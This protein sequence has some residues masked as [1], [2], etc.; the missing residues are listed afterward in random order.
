MTIQHSK[1]IT[2]LCRVT[3]MA[4]SALI[5]LFYTTPSNAAQPDAGSL[6]Q[7]QR[8][9]KPALPQRLPS[10]EVS[11]VVQEADAAST[12]TFFVREFRFTG[13]YDNLVTS[14][15]LTTLVKEHIGKECTLGELQKLMKTITNYLRNKKQYLLARAYLPPQDVTQGVIEI[16]I[17]PGHVEGRTTIEL[18]KP[19][20]ISAHLL[21]N[22]ADSAIPE[23]RPAT[24][25][26]LERA[27]LLSNDLPGVTAR[28][29]L[30]P[31]S[32]PGSTRL[33][34][35]ASEKAL[36]QGYFSGDNHGSLYTGQLRG[37]AAI[38]AYH[39]FGGGDQ[40]TLFLMSAEQMQ[41]WQASYSTL[42]FPNGLT[43]TLSFSSL[44]YN[45]ARELSNLN[46]SGSAKTYSAAL[47]YPLLRTRNA[48]IWSGLGGEALALRDK[49]N[50]VSI[51][52]RN[53][54]TGKISLTGSFFD[55][56]GG[57]GLSNASLGVTTGNADLSSLESNLLADVSGPRTHGNFLRTNY[58][59]ARLQRL[60]SVTS[61]FLAARGQLASTNLDSAQKFI[62][63]GPAGVRAYPVGESV[64]DEGHAF[65]LESRMELPLMPANVTTQLIGFYDT[66][67]VKLNRNPWIGAV[68]NATNSNYYWLSGAGIGLNMDH[69]GRYALRTAYAYPVGSNPGRTHMG[70]NAD[71]EPNKGRFWAQ[72]IVWF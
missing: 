67:W 61:L 39:P 14:A 2:G 57:G 22:I 46:A 68:N 44:S 19:S 31:G 49:A 9:S 59:F 6:L 37:N 42:L 20:H 8:Q 53:I 55:R 72:L 23:G 32:E 63:G 45:I 1:G 56:L 16:A 70:T 15:E 60:T 18:D 41:Q 48:S 71:N 17:V 33:V 58:T 43:G 24:M 28:G 65:T 25:K 69:T 34:I 47:S 51:R 26:S 35:K 4:F 50:G 21:Q 36:F 11:D 7:E 52:E 54:Y 38:S 62:L 27:V 40:A 29:S 3:F 12:I 5:T 64:A 66:G 10:P 30:E 13:R